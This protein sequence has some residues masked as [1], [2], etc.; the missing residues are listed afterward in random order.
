[1]LKGNTGKLISS[2]LTLA[3]ILTALPLVGVGASA[4]VSADS[5]WEYTVLDDSTAMLGDDTN[6]NSAYLGNSATP[7]IPAVIDGYTIVRISSMAFYGN[8]AISEVTIPDTV[9]SIGYAAFYGCTSLESVVVPDSVQMLEGEVFYGC[10]SLESVTLPDNGLLFDADSFSETAAFAD[11]D[12]WTGGGFYIGDYLIC[13]SP[14]VTDFTVKNGT[15]YVSANAFLGNGTI[16]TV[17]MPNSVTSIWYGFSECSSLRSVV[18]SDSI[19]SLEEMSFYHCES[20]ESVTL[21]SSLESIGQCAFEGCS[22]LDNVVLPDGLTE[23]GSYAFYH[24]TSLSHIEIPNGVTEIKESTFYRCEGLRSIVIPESVTSIGADAFSS[25]RYL[26][27]VT[28][29][30]A[31]TEIDSTAFDVT[32][33]V[34]STVYGYVGSTAQSFAEENGITF[35]PLGLVFGD[36]DS[37]G[38]VTIADYAV[39]KLYLEGNTELDSLGFVTADVNHDNAVDAFDLFEVNKIIYC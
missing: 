26:D 20:L 31:D 14:E 12:N 22:L 23:I 11:T 30:N 3:S 5:L 28:F 24:C 13:I 37:D 6:E 32:K 2:L 4:Q 35:I 36:L 10:T 21:P 16:E 25:C 15:K 39:I 7:V 9:E 1:M 33:T 34:I 17:T 19:T 27:E 18:L 8:T 38:D 29:L